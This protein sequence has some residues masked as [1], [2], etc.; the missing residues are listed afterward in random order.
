[1]CRK[2]NCARWGIHFFISGW[3]GASGARRTEAG[4]PAVFQEGSGAGC[5]EAGTESTGRT[6]LAGEELG[7][8]YF[9][10][11]AVL[12]CRACRPVA[13]VVRVDAGFVGRVRK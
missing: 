2:D 7:P 5:G 10:Q 8:Q 3:D 12:M 6:G 11:E 1:M 4:S 13:A 9:R